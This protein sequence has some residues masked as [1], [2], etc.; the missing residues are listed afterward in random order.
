L[1]YTVI[2][3]RMF[4]A[5]RDRWQEITIILTIPIIRTKE[6]ALTGEN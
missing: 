5:R 4:A 3:E 6:T 2:Y 1:G